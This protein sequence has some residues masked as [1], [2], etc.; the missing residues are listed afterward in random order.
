MTAGLVDQT[1]TPPAPARRRRRLTL[2]VV[3]LGIAALRAAA[4]SDEGAVP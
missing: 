2:P 1:I 4:R 3:L